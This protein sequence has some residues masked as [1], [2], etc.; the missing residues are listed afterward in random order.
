[1]FAW[2]Q[3]W[4]VLTAMPS[5]QSMYLGLTS[6]ELL[7]ARDMSDGQAERIVSGLGSQQ[8]RFVSSA[9]GSMI[10][11]DGEADYLET[12]LYSNLCVR[13]GLPYMG[14]SQALDTFLGYVD[15]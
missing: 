15:E 1:M 2:L 4:Y 13:C 6:D 5:I 9:L 14:P 8:K 3:K 7:E 11:I 10:E 12:S